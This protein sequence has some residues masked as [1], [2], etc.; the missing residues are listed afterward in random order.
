[1]VLNQYVLYYNIHVNILN[2]TTHQLLFFLQTIMAFSHS[3]INNVVLHPIN[4]DLISKIL[5]NN[6]YHVSHDD[7]MYHIEVKVNIVLH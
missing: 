5:S 2:L 4:L 6:V 1:M 7:K 3:Y